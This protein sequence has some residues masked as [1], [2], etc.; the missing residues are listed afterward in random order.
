MWLQNQ[1]NNMRKVLAATTTCLMVLFSIVSSFDLQ[2]QNGKFDVRIKLKNSDCVAK[3]ITILVQVKA[4]DATSTFKMG[5]ANFRFDYDPL[6]VKTPKNVS[7]ETFSNATPASDLNYTGQ[8]LTGSQV[9]PD[10]TKGIVS[11][12]VL[13]SGSN[14]GA[15]LV[16]NTDYITVACIQFDIVS[17]TGC[18]NFRCVDDVKLNARN[19][20][21]I[22]ITHQFCTSVTA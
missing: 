15:K 10:G 16:S 4:H 13:Y 2:A 21:I 8:T 11:L 17:T 6:V 22:R 12:N 1:L 19:G 5:D 14:A 9:S 3:K 18:V 7:Q 20:Y